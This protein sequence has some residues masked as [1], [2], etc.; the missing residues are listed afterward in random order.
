MKHALLLLATFVI[1]FTQT[2]AQS[3]KLETL[4]VGRYTRQSDGVLV[5]SGFL[6]VSSKNFESNGGTV[7]PESSLAIPAAD[8]TAINGK[9]VAFKATIDTYNQVNPG[10]LD[11]YSFSKSSYAVVG[12]DAYIVTFA[13]G[14]D[15]SAP[16]A[17][18]SVSKPKLK[19]GS[20]ASSKIQV[21]LSKATKSDILVR[22]KISGSAKLNSDYRVSGFESTVKIKKGSKSGSATVT[23]NNDTQKEAE[24]TVTITVKAGTQYKVGKRKKATIK[25]GDDDK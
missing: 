23:L 4:Q 6:M 17:S 16:T 11:N 25:I 3:G 14:E 19:E 2:H 12:G 24:E 22:Y 7:Y 9:F 10:F 15:A 20:N 18:L 21:Q 8:L 1:G 13:T 5:E